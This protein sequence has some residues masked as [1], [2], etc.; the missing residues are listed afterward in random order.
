MCIGIEYTYVHI[1]RKPTC[2]KQVL[3]NRHGQSG[4]HFLILALKASKQEHS[5]VFSETKA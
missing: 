2:C 1:E 5:F 3:Y 4:F